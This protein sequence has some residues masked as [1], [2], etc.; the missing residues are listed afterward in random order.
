LPAPP[1]IP[2]ITFIHTDR[3]DLLFEHCFNSFCMPN[4]AQALMSGKHL[5]ARYAGT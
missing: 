2:I 5:N 1:G 4:L 3:N